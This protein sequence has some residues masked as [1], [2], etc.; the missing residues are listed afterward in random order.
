LG[1]ASNFDGRLRTVLNGIA[2][3]RLLDGLIISSEV[4]WRKPALQFFVAVAARLALE[5]RE[6]LFIGDSLE[7]DYRGAVAA[8]MP[9]LLLDEACRHV[10]TN[11]RRIG[12]LRDLIEA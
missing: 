10:Q 9:A 6:I 3:H 8:G 5:P 2:E 12:R 11:C 1:V 7:N 4:G